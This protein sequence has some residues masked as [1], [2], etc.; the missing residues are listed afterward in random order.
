MIYFKTDLTLI[1]RGFVKG[2]SKGIVAYVVYCH[3]AYIETF[4]VFPSHRFLLARSKIAK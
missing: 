2:N 1:V 4:D 3:G